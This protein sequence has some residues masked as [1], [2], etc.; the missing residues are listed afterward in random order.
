MKIV[1]IKDGAVKDGILV[2]KNM[3]KF[4]LVYL[5]CFALQVS[6]FASS[7]S[8]GGASG[9]G[10]GN[11]TQINS[12][13]TAA[14]TLTVGTTGT[15]FVVVDD[16]AGDHKFNLPSASGTARGLVTTGSQTIAGAKTLSTAPILSSLTATTIP[17]LDGSKQLASSAVTPT[18]LGYVTG[19]TSAIQTQIN[20]KAPSASPAF[21]T[22]VTFGN[23]HLEPCETDDGNS[24]T[25][26]T[27]DLSSC[28]V[29]K[30]TLT[31]NVTYTLTNPVTGGSYLIRI[32]TGAGSFTVTWPATVKWAGGTAP[33]IT[34]TASKMDLI[35]LYWDGTNYYGSFTQAYTP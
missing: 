35:N 33:T 26:D 21:T 25:A 28:A 2:R 13:A 16:A 8:S 9:G 10:S 1:L 17:Y 6:S 34:A 30:S 20:T 4:S 11:V 5:L 18:E 22:Q 14:Q 3:T 23:Y 29:R 24:S 7:T 15:D 19:V 12:D 32:L 31:G 27:L